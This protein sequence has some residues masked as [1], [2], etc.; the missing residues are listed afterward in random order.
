MCSAIF[1]ASCHEY[2]TFLRLCTF[3][4]SFSLSGIRPR[5]E[6]GTFRSFL[7]AKIIRCMVRSETL[8]DIHERP[9]P[10]FL[11][12]D[13][14]TASKVIRSSGTSFQSAS[15][16]FLIL[17]SQTERVDPTPDALLG[18]TSPGN[19]WLRHQKFVQKESGMNSS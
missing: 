19:A 16:W 10:R 8:T 13:S 15:R 6:K 11:A 9:C 1:T 17:P 12:A 5:W 18:Q 7:N 3:I 4:R 2:E 14:L